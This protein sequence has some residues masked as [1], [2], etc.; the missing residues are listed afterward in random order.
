MSTALERSVKSTGG[1]N[2]FIVTYS[3]LADFIPILSLLNVLY[4]Q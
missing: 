4:H 3:P 2:M 1:L